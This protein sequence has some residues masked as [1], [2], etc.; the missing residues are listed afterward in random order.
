[1]TVTSICDIRELAIAL[2]EKCTVDPGADIYNGEDGQPWNVDPVFVVS[3]DTMES[4]TKCFAVHYDISIRS[5]QYIPIREW[6]K[7]YPSGAIRVSTIHLSTV[8]AQAT[9]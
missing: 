9:W 2:V 4:D 6:I 5:I 8:K 3:D 7:S 1:M